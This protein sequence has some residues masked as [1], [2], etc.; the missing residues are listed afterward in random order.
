MRNILIILI[1]L[2]LISCSEES[3]KSN[4]ENKQ[5]D[6]KAEVSQEKTPIEENND[7]LANDKLDITVD[8]QETEQ[9]DRAISTNT[10]KPI[11]TTTDSA[12]TESADVKT[13]IQV[14][15]LP[16]MPY[17]PTFNVSRNDIVLGNIKAN[18]VV[19]EYFSPTCPHCAYYHDIILPKLKEKYI[20]T[21]KIAYIIREFIGNKQDLDAAILQRCPNNTDS[22]LKFQS[23]I[24][25]QQDKW[26]VSN[27]YRELLTN[28]AQIGGVSA[29]TY[30]K[31]LN[32]NQIVE[33]LLANT[34][35]A[36]SAPNFVGT[37]T[38]FVN[39]IQT[40]G[41]DLQTLSK[42]IDKALNS[43]TTNPI[44]K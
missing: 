24:L 14:V 16:Q 42:E 37:P 22:F 21:N 13:D 4:N 15:S 1:S 25:S 5:S 7:N 29:E 9:P 30:A 31:C 23:V 11:D 33:T 8:N 40:N 12:K 39:G 41:Y 20:D 35:L 2:L 26:G 36:A 18:V 19:V 38:F 10:D 17:K 27:R 34:N 28:I 43:S 6:N 32:D 44:L 3:D